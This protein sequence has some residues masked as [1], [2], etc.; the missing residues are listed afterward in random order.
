MNRV[1]QNKSLLSQTWSFMCSEGLPCLFVI[2]MLCN[3][4]FFAYA[5][6]DTNHSDSFKVNSQHTTSQT[7]SKNNYIN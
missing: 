3:G 1:K 7:V 6:F 5:L 2:L 4:L